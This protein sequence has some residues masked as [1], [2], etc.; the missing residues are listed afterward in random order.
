MLRAPPRPPEPPSGA[1]PGEE[2][3]AS[4]AGSI[5]GRSLALSAAAPARSAPSFARRLGGRR[6]RRVLAVGGAVLLLLVVA[7]ALAFGPL[8]R[9][10]VASEGERRN[11]DI[12]VGGVRPGFFAVTLRDV[13]VRPRGVSGVEARIDA[14]RVDLGATLSVREVQAKGGGLFIEG[15]PE[16]VADR[17]RA[18]RRSA[19]DNKDASEPA[20]ARTPM[21]AEDLALSWKLPS[22]GELTGSGIRAAREADGI[23][24][25]CAKCAAR[26]RSVTLEVAEADVELAP[27]GAPRRVTASTLGV[28]Y[29][30]PRAEALP[31]ATTAA[32][33]E[34]APPPLPALTKRG[35]KAAAKPAVKAVAAL[36]P[37]PP[38]EPVLPL[39]DLHA[40]R[41]KIAGAAAAFAP[42]VPDGAVVEIGGLSVKL[43]VGGEPMAFGPGPFTLTRRG[44]RIHLGFTSAAPA[45]AADAAGTGGPPH[46]G[47]AGP[48]HA[49]SPT[50]APAGGTPLSID[51][52]LPVT[53]GEM[54]ARLAGGPVSLAVLGVKEGMKGLTDVTRGT[55]SGKGQLVLSEAADALTFDGEV[56]LRSISLRQ[57]RLA[58]ELLRGIEFTLSARGLL[59]DRGK[60]R[61]DDAELDMGALH[62]RTH[63]TVEESPEHFAV[64]LAIDVAPAACQA[65]L[66]SS[67]QGLLPIV[68]AARMG[69]TFGASVNLAF[70]T[71]TIDKLSLDYRIGDQCRMLEVPRDLS[72][73]RFD[74][75]FSYRTYKPDGTLGETTTGPGTATWTALDDISPFMVAAVLTTEDGAFYRH[76]GFNHAA[77]RSSV[78]ANLK[79]R[80]FVRGASTITMQLAKN[81]FLARDKALARKIEEVILTD[82]LEQTFRKDD[83]MELYLNVVEFGPDVY[84]ITQAAEHYF[85]RKPEELHLAECFFLASLLPSPIRYGKLRDKGEVSET[86]MRHLTALMEIAAKNGKISAAELEE[87]RKEPVVFMRPGDP[88]PEP[89]KPVTSTRRDPSDDDAAWTPLD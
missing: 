24:L 52:D 86:W 58:P 1:Q 3:R 27:D 81:L 28:T 2:R 15:E 25:G 8:V 43:D 62:L 40:L 82:Y 89:R 76:K 59:D 21:R 61:V 53:T 38:D 19:G 36:A 46:A 84:G 41:A 55:V 83:M 11:L 14:L 49:A 29:D 32:P 88:R 71:R 65:L 42:R 73:E 23:R 87:G 16:D 18:F 34:P 77:I 7:G 48:P 60:L 45:D 80:R 20:R 37:A 33:S 13:R 51:A 35:A 68:R 17:L 31:P 70:D 44:D 10:R 5:E 12:D 69:G 9:S 63:G 75:P 30:A 22:G 57:P 47:T 64:S 26:H 66:D 54:T 50:R 6:A 79:A 4:S 85:G 78:Q 72:R 56:T 74:G 67:P 39:P